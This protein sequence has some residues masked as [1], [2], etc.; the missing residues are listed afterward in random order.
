MLSIK[1][2]KVIHKQAQYSQLTINTVEPFPFE[3]Q[4]ALI[5]FETGSQINVR[6][7]YMKSCMNVVI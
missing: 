4:I 7:L 2:I 3:I 5:N 6:L 1:F